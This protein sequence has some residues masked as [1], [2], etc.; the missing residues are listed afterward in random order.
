M[1]PFTAFTI[2]ERANDMFSFPDMFANE[3]ESYIAE[4]F[5]IKK[6]TG[7]DDMAIVQYRQTSLLLI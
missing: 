1:I 5:V 3:D 6:E 7:K 4:V 2:L